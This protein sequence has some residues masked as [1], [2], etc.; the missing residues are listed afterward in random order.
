MAL[1]AGVAAGSFWLVPSHLVIGV[2]C[3]TW[4]LALTC[5]LVRSTVWF[6]GSALVAFAVCGVALGTSAMWDAIH[7]PARAALMAAHGVAELPDEPSGIVEVTGRL[8]ED[9]APS[10]AGGARLAVES[11]TFGIGDRTWLAGGGIVVSVVGTVDP[12]MAATWRRGRVVRVPAQLRRP[13]RYLDPGVPDFELMLAR[14]GITLVGSAKSGLLVEVMARGSVFD[15]TCAELRARARDVFDRVIGRYG[16]RSAAVAR[17]VILG[18]R[19]GLDQE[20]EER[21]QRAGT[22]HVIAISGGNIAILAG[23]LFAAARLVTRV[24]VIPDVAVSACLI[25]Y[26]FLVGGGASVTRATV[27]AVVLLAGHAFDG[28]GRPLNALACAA[29]LSLA[30][31]PLMIYDAGAWLTYGATLAIIVGSPLAFAG[32]PRLP[33]WVRPIV[34]LLVASLAAELALFPI[35]ALVFSRVTAAGLALNFA[36]IPLM[37]VVQVGGMCVLGLTAVAAPAAS[38]A[39]RVSH[40]AAWGLVESAR[41]VDLVPWLTTR[42]PPPGVVAMAIYYLAWLV[43]F[44]IPHLPEMGSPS[45]GSDPISWKQRWG[46]TPCSDVRLIF[47]VRSAAVLVVI[48][49]GIW[50]VAAPA[51][52]W[53]AAGRLRVTFIDVGQGDATLIQFPSGHAWMVDAGGATGPR[54]DIARRVIEPVVWTLGVRQLAHL[55]LTHGDADHIGGA[56]SIV[57]DL[58]PDE[59]WEGIPVPKHEPLRQLRDLTGVSGSVWRTV[60]RGDRLR[61]GGVDVIVWHPPPADWERQRVRNDDSIVIELHYGNVAIVLAGDIEAPSEKALA[62]LLTPAPI[63]IVQAPHHGSP[64]S[65]SLP[66]LQAMSPAVVVMSVGRNNRFGHPGRA[67]VERYRATGAAVFRTDQDGA[68]TIDTDGNTADVTSFTGRRQHLTPAAPPA[69]PLA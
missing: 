33:V 6:V 30:I 42:L 24:P 25:G 56:P 58:L 8:T 38:V 36:A 49:T 15:E 16:A 68:I 35:A 21:L 66:L 41:L 53:G 47:R 43:F 69:A 1:L 14:R 60:Q 50:I 2:V 45:M 29:G 57:R 59:V 7:T 67:V 31:E 28:R 39:G 17:A 48:A 64:S 23:L 40:L 20:T 51:V 3:V 26:A 18:D 52:R 27:M 44:A 63:T 10:A 65:S 54:F 61:I 19:T 13:A 5:L 46:L 55:V 4:G 11:T 34:A 37:T 22:Y 9:A 62:R 32:L 12:S